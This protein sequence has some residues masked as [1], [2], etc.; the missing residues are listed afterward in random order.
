MVPQLSGGCQH[1]YVTKT[2]QT[3]CANKQSI[4]SAMSMGDL[5]RL[6]NLSWANIKFIKKLG[7]GSWEL[8]AGSWELGAGS[9]ELGAGSWEPGAGA[10][11]GS[12]EREPEARSK[13]SNRMG[14]Y[15]C[16]VFNINDE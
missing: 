12:Q 8:G 1:N 11:S 16:L 15:T 13:L 9:W 4:Y 6:E 5:L 3:G 10:R 7:A 14:L 2:R